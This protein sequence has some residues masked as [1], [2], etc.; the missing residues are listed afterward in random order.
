LTIFTDQKALGEQFD[1]LKSLRLFEL[2]VAVANSYRL[3]LPYGRLP[4]NWRVVREELKPGGE[5]AEE[6][7]HEY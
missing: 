5:L 2:S 3:E 7:D 4:T 6:K 1:P